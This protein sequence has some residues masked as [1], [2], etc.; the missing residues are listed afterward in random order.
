MF[1]FFIRK[2]EKNCITD[3]YL[4]MYVEN[5]KKQNEYAFYFQHTFLIFLMTLSIF[6]ESLS[7][8]LDI[9][10]TTPYIFL[11]KKKKQPK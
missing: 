10:K 3:A 8:R 2:K 4:S 7:S 11:G 1:W 9:K 5:K 6:C